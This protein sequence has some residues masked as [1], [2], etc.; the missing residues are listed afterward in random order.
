MDDYFVV[1]QVDLQREVLITGIQ[2]QGAKQ[3]T[4]HLYTKE[5]FIAYSKNGRR[6]I[7]FRGNST[8]AQKV[9]MLIGFETHIHYIFL[10]FLLSD[11]ASPFL[12]PL[13]SHQLPFTPSSPTIFSSPF[14]HAHLPSVLPIHLLPPISIS[15]SNCLLLP[16]CCQ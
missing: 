11:S 10:S 3:L 4:T 6:W 8:G 12:P 1:V 2:T 13:L 16:G 15:P 14:P 9:C 7:A 5:Y